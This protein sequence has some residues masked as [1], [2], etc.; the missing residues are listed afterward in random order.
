MKGLGYGLWFRDNT[1]LDQKKHKFNINC[2]KFVQAFYRITIKR[3]FLN[4]NKINGSKWTYQTNGKKRMVISWKFT[5]L[6]PKKCV[7]YNLKTMIFRELHIFV[8][9][10]SIFSY[11]CKISIKFI[12]SFG[13]RHK[14][15]F[16]PIIF[17]TKNTFCHQMETQW[18]FWESRLKPPL[19]QT[20][21]QET[22]CIKT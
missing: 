6:I 14:H 18:P 3:W 19:S 9:I 15:V 7:F 8:I 4:E 17:S 16:R 12:H 10:F 2:Y 11:T 21:L 5:S 1:S 20:R 13:W 22:L